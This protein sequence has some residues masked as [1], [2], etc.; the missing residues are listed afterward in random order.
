MNDLRSHTVVG[1]GGL[2]LSVYQRGPE[3]APTLL[4]VHGYP[5]DHA[6]WDLV[7]DRLDA[8]HHVVTYDVRGAGDSGVPEDHRGYRMEALIADVVAV[9]AAVS[10]GQPVHLGGHDWGSIQCWAA[11]TDPRAAEHFASYTSMSG[12]S[13]DH[14]G[15]WIRARLMPGRGRWGQLRRQAMHSWYVFA[16]HTPLGPLVWRHGLDRVWPTLLE[17]REGVTVDER[18]PSRRICS[19]ASKSWRAPSPAAMSAEGTG[20]PGRS[21]SRWPVWWPITWPTSGEPRHPGPPGPFRLAG[22]APPL[23]PRRS[24]DHPHHQRAAPVAPRW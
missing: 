15:A 10:P 13:L 16:F 14:V 20:C 5:D 17:R 1:F 2:A 6:V 19:K 8:D 24:S 3:A 12:P 21:R 4:F 11:I 9:A 18:W 22:H 23:D 7:A